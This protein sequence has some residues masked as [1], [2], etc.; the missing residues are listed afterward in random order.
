MSDPSY[1]LQVAQVAALKADTALQA[2]IGN[3][4]RVYDR[5]TA[6]A[7]FPYVQVGGDGQVLE[8]DAEDCADGS[9]VYTR[10]HVW[11]RATGFPE[12]K[13]IAAEVRRVLK[14]ALPLDGFTISVFQFVQSTPLRDPDGQTLHVIVEHRY[15]ITHTA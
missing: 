9:E 3:P 10:T 2:L 5:V 1:A 14:A 7:V 6:D 11:S 13:K 12:A 4:P 15:L 8:D